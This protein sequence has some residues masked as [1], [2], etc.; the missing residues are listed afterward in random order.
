M[1][2]RLTAFVALL[3]LCFSLNISA[4][5]AENTAKYILDELDVLNSQE[6]NDLNAYADYLAEKT[7]VDFIFV[8]TDQTD[9]I[10][11]YALTLSLG[12]SDNK[13][14]MVVND[15]YWDLTLA[16]TALITVSSAQEDA[17]GEAFNEEDYYDTAVAAYMK[18]AASIFWPD[19][20][21]RINDYQTDGVPTGYTLRLVDNADLL[22][23]DE[24]TTLLAKLDEISER[25]Q[26]DI[27]VVTVDTLDGKTPMDYADDF[28]DYN[29]Y[30]FGDTNDGV[31]LLVSMEDRDWWMSTSG[32]GITAITDAGIEYISDKFLS[33]LS[34][35]NYAEAFSTYAQLCDEFFTQ[36]KTGQPYDVGH[37]PKEPFNIVWNLFVALIVGF[38]IALI[39]TNIMKGKLKTVRFQYAAGNYVKENSMNITDSRDMFLYTHVD[40]IA[41][42]KETSSSSGGS[43]THTS[44]SGATHGGGGGKF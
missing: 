29:G 4:F 43:S 41:K 16:G 22:N 25:Q 24:E 34:D 28:Y 23:D 30:G 26:A 5:A 2:R 15:E 1:K 40:R 42:P 12:K 31:L 6:E 21:S 3:M 10:A 13:I 37:M 7:G 36:A 27:V 18:E 32:Y 38:V 33:D 20:G 44:S 14:V 8:T 9:D 19:D 11:G 35:G 17:L 39:A